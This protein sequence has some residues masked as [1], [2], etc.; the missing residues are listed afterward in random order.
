MSATAPTIDREACDSRSGPVLDT[1]READGRLGVCLPIEEVAVRAAVSPET[2]GAW[3]D[4]GLLPVVDLPT[5]RG[6]L[7]PTTPARHG[8]PVRIA[9]GRRML[10]VRET[11]WIKFL[12]KYERR[13][14]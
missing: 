14:G 8:A 4:R 3:I 11:T 10:R 1:S 13:R 9:R 7:R 12:L 2:V 5:G 6:K